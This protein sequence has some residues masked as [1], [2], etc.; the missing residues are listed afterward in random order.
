MCCRNSHHYPCLRTIFMSVFLAT[1]GEH[2]FLVRLNYTFSETVSPLFC[3]W[4]M[5]PRWL[6]AAKKMI[7]L[8]RRN[9]FVKGVICRYIVIQ[10]RHFCCWLVLWIQNLD[11]FRLGVLQ[12]FTPLSLPQ[13]YIYVG[14]FGHRW[15]AFLL[16]NGSLD[17]PH[18]C[19]LIPLSWIDVPHSSV[20]CCI[21]WLRQ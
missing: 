19:D 15:R 7:A 10:M 1:D 12:E 3:T 20:L 8:M 21:V 9:S 4:C 11:I 5:H 2:F 14:I 16:R 17:A 6:I 13:N 18:L